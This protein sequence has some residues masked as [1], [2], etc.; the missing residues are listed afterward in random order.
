MKKT[1]LSQFEEFFSTVYYDDVAEI[2]DKYPD[3]RSL[4]V[5]YEELEK[6]NPELAYE[7]NNGIILCQF[8]HD[9]Y[10]SVYGL[11]DINPVKLAK[12]IRRFSS[13]G[14]PLE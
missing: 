2:L 3:E 4:T 1:S 9:K 7:V 5:N 8:C 12:F 11:K 14:G 10:H 6:F 13:N